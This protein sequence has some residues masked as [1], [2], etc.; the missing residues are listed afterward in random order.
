MYPGLP[1]MERV[2]TKHDVCPAHQATR[3]LMMADIPDEERNLRGLLATDGNRK[4]LLNFV[5]RTTRF[6]SVFG[7]IAEIPDQD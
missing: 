5:A 4:Q 2:T 6:R 1:Y 3:Q 7:H